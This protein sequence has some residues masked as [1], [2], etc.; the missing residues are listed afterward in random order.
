MEETVSR[1]V[2]AR[3]FKAI[4]KRRGHTQSEI[5]TAMEV[6]PATV[7][8]WAKGL[9]FPRIDVM[10]RLASFLD[11]S[12][13]SML[14]EGLEKAYQEIDDSERLEALHQNPKLGLLFDKSRK[15][16]DKDIDAMLA[17]A[18]RI[19]NETN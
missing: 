17:I 16:T 9:K 19:L 3:N 6:S 4:L 12:V 2:F 10:Q 11:V 18:G 5:A 1:A 14:S 13:T 15:M 7:S 8:A